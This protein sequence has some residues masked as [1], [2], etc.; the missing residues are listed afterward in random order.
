MALILATGAASIPHAVLAQVLGGRVLDAATHQPVA[1]L[2]VRLLR[3][4]PADTGRHDPAGRDTIP[5]ARATTGPDGAFLLA[6]PAPGTYRAQIGEG[7]VTQP[8]VL[9]DAESFEDREYLLAALPPAVA[10]TPA[11]PAAPSPSGATPAPPP[12]T[13]EAVLTA[14]AQDSTFRVPKHT[15]RGARM[16]HLGSEATLCVVPGER[17]AATVPGTLRVEYPEVLLNGGA[18][19]DSLVVQFVVDTAGAAD[20]S[21]FRVLDVTDPV[22][23]QVTRTAL[24]SA[25]FRPAEIGHHKVRQLVELPITFE[26]SMRP[27]RG[28]RGELRAPG[29]P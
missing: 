4:A 28:G 2:P 10:V 14:I 20:L 8:I 5:L 29:L 27:R 9:A 11:G 18:R 26:V 19:R 1:G 17:L 24:A 12:C 7:F 23:V 21:T 16:L 25:R 3:A 6:A 15:A 13:S 22:F